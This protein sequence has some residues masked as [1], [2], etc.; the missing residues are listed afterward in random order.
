MLGCHR[1]INRCDVVLAVDPGFHCSLGS[2]ARWMVVPS[3][4]GRVLYHSTEL[5]Q[6]VYSLLGPILAIYPIYI[7][8]NQLNSAKSNS[9]GL[10]TNRIN[11]YDI[12]NLLISM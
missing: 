5:I 10:S 12:E 1:E 3:S 6:N 4:M 7:K 9:E 8:T 2:C 11:D